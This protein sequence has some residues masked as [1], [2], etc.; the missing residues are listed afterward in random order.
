MIL[1]DTT[2]L[3]D[4]FRGRESLE[5]LIENDTGVTTTLNYY[6]IMTGIRR[7]KS[8]R[9]ENFFKTFFAKIELLDFTTQAAEESSVL[10]SK[11]S[12]LGLP[13]NNLDVLIAGTALAHG[14]DTILTRDADF[15]GIGKISDLCINVYDIEAQ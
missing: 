2:F 8:K 4:Y 13:V 11:L 10:S 5:H 9:E 14:I 6:E 3:I 15:I 1:L 7:S 12:A